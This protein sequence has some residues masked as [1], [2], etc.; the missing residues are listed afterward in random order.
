MLRRLRAD[1]TPLPLYITENG[2]AYF[3]RLDDGRVQDAERIAYLSDHLHAV[4]RAIQDGVDV[5]GYY[6][7]SLMDNFEWEWGY[8]RRFGVVYIDYATQQRI[9][10]DSGTWYKD[11]IVAA[12]S[13]TQEH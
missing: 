8:S 5:R 2:A 6:V 12:K 3:D 4:S 13:N 7:W 11:F 9:I 1:F 10:K